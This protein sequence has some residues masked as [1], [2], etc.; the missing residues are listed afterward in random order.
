MENYR[1]EYTSISNNFFILSSNGV[2]VIWW[3]AG[4]FKSSLKELSVLA[5]HC[6]HDDVMTA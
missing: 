2:R 3:Y 1:L 5:H 4:Y 6:R